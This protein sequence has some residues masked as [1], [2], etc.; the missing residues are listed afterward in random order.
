MFF[1]LAEVNANKS[2]NPFIKIFLVLIL[3]CISGFRYEIGNDY[4]HYVLIFDQI[5]G[6]SRIEPGY[7]GLISLVKFFGGNVQA[8]FMLS[9]I[10]AIV[11]LAYVIDKVFPKYF[12]VAITVYVFTYI[13]FEG[14]NTVR[15]A[16]SMAIMFYAFK[17]YL[18]NR[19]ILKYVVLVLLAVLF[20]YSVVLVAIP[21]WFIMRFS[22]KNINTVAFALA[23]ILSF[24]IGYYI[25]SFTNQIVGVANLI[26]RGDSMYL[27]NIEQ[28]GVNS[29]IFHYVLN[30]YA[31]A[32]L[33]FSY[34]KRNFLSEMDNGILKLFFTAIITYNLFINFYI[35]LR[36]YWYFYLLITLAIPVVLVH[37]NKKNRALAFI[38]IL[39]VFLVY[40]YLSLGSVYYS[41]YKYTFELVR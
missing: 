4:Y 30:F 5:E 32:F 23:L 13:Y 21:G 29:G 19:K 6:Y 18:T 24:V 2:F 34:I 27:D 37:I 3:V 35:G 20:H 15:Q 16:I 36:L 7:M 11:P 22:G 38:V 12:C 17:D 26:G 10:L 31:I 14:M 41:P 39:S 28:R 25:N 33:I 40:T 1:S 9:A 8:M